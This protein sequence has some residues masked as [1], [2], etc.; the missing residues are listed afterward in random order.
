MLLV[1]AFVFVYYTSWAIIL[2]F[3]DATSPVHDYFPAREWAIRLPAFILVLGLS[4]I[5]FFVGSTV[6]K[7]NR[8]KA[9]KARSRNA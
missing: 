7:E 9:Q 5:G 3:F 8:K 6:I 4:G 1:A 2:P